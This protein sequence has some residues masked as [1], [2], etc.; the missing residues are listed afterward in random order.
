MAIVKPEY[1]ADLQKS[2]DL[3]FWRILDTSGRLELNRCLQDI[4]LDASIDML[5]KDLENTSGD[6]VVVKLY[7]NKPER[8]ENGN[9]AETA[10]VRKVS[11][12]PTIGK[13][14]SNSFGSAPGFEFM[15]QMME[16]S[17][18]T[19][20]QHLTKLQELQLEMMEMKLNDNK[21]D[22]LLTQ[23]I[24]AL[25]YIQSFMGGKNVLGGSAPAKAAKI[26]GRDPEVDSD[27]L[28]GVLD[29]FATLDPDYINTLEKMAAAVEENPN[30]LPALKNSL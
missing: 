18:Q 4:G 16:R 12:S 13:A 3:R 26:S 25:P 6:Y 1:I 30:I 21:Q 23:L 15:F 11:L 2:Q 19:E 22:S 27:R 10:I 7:S 17:K 5:Q 29:K 9:I 20:I 28:A 8:K 14:Q 24:S